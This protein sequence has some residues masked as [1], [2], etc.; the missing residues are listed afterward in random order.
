MRPR[1]MAL[2]AIWLGLVICGNGQAQ[3]TFTDPAGDGK[4]APDI[5]SVVIS[6]DNKGQVTIRLSVVGDPSPA[7]F[8]VAFDTDQNASTGAPDSLGTEYAL[9]YMPGANSFDFV[10]WNG[11]QWVSAPYQT[12]KVSA[13]ATSVTLSVNVNEL[14]GVH[15]FG[16][17]TRSL[18]GEVTNGVLDDAPDTGIYSY[19]FELAADTAPPHV[20]AL[21]SSGRAGTRIHLT[22][23][24]YDDVSSRTYERIRVFV[25]G[26]VIWT[27]T[28]AYGTAEQGVDYWVNWKPP[29]RL[30]GTFRFCVESW[31]ES[32]NKSSPSCARVRVRP[33]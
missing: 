22:Y 31:D 33:S 20:K 7:L 6:N 27:Y 16:F 28:V 4:G 13:D 5:T 12:V 11:S 21:P 26:T 2:L 1:V 15:S 8:G 32:K 17:W 23:E 18:I 14:G 29:K 19:A 3:T 10:R 9:T 24:V 25:R 30:V